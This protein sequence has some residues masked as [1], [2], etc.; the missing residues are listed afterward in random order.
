MLRVRTSVIPALSL[1][2][3][4]F[5]ASHSYSQE[6]LRRFRVKS[7]DSQ[8]IIYHIYDVQA[9]GVIDISN[10][11]LKDGVQGQADPLNMFFSDPE[12]IKIELLE[13]KLATLRDVSKATQE[14]I[15][16]QR[17]ANTPP[18]VTIPPLRTTNP[19]TSTII[20][21]PAPKEGILSKA[22]AYLL[23]L[24]D[25]F[26]TV[27]LLLASLG[28]LAPIGVRINREMRL[29]K[30]ME[31]LFAGDQ[32][33]GKTA[34]F[35][36]VRNPNVSRYVLEQLT[37][38]EKM[39]PHK[40]KP[41]PVGKYEIFP[42]LFDSPG[43]KPAL[44]FKQ[45]KALFASRV[46][47]YVL[48]PSDKPGQDLASREALEYRS[49]QLGYMKVFL[50]VMLLADVVIKPK[51]VCLFINKFDLF[52]PHSPEDSQARMAVKDAQTMFSEHIK[53]FQLVA[54]Q[55]GL[56]PNFEFGSAFENW[57]CDKIRI[58]IEQALDYGR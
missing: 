53:L 11:S 15:E 50:E 47:V 40:G 5:L 18:K 27:I 46:L 25:R 56:K 28:V 17:K 48:A 35:E 9:E 23:P 31:L 6:S 49:R 8:K 33:A 42:N 12:S 34:L 36:R 16:A 19:P 4:I 10:L 20:P 13:R 44:N 54:K 32:A 21:P 22:K 37:A 43:S 55:A 2:I 52:S 26:R 57:N 7:I 24:W 58:H 41:F 45:K 29:K 1:A 14:E 3:L 38:T 51:T 39:H 30:R